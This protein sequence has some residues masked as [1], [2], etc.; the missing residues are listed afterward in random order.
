MQLGSSS[1]G[2]CK[3]L[4]VPVVSTRTSA[5]VPAGLMSAAVRSVAVPAFPAGDR[6]AS[7]VVDKGGSPKLVCQLATDVSNGQGYILLV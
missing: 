2:N 7:A 3:D 5:T 1:R 6:H 4:P